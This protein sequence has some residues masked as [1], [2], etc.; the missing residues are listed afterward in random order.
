MT[1]LA[2]KNMSYNDIQVISPS[3]FAFIVYCKKQKKRKQAEGEA[4]KTPVNS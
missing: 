3:H 1:K 2:L 4:I